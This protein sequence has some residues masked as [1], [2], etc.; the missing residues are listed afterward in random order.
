MSDLSNA[1]SMP[2]EIE[3][4]YRARPHWLAEKVHF[5][6]YMTGYALA[7]LL[8]PRWTCAAMGGMMRN[9]GPLLGLR[10]R[11][12]GNFDLVRPS[13]DDAMRRRI[14]RGVFDNFARTGFEYAFIPYLS[15]VA[16]DWR[17]EGLEHYLA[18]REAAGGRV[19]IA[20]AHVGNWEAVRAVAAL[21]GPPL[22]LIYRA[23]NNKFV[24]QHIFRKMTETG[25]PA[26]RKGAA[27]GRALF[28]HVRNGGGAMI[29]VDQRLGGAPILDFMG[30]P[31]E[32]SLAAAQMAKTLKAPLVPA[33]AFRNEG[34]FTVRFEAPIAP[35]QPDEMMAEVNRRV[36][37]W[38]DHAPEQWL[39]M[40]RRWK[41]RASG[42]VRKFGSRHAS[43][44]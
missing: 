44:A 18:A 13:Y 11:A 22:G 37:A 41:V 36:E 24:D 12:Y 28:K 16:V 38:V 4:A 3:Y 34:G 6:G 27:G 9:V 2:A 7:K 20:S 19:I 42:R 21:H 1:A 43:D 8:G 33:V 15:R 40:H 5:G 26:F 23:F 35:A 10:K 32:T 29:L 31:A 17:V 14:V 25:W 39:W 30:Q